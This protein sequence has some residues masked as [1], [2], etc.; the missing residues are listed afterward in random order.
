MDGFIN[1]VTMNGKSD[2]SR[3]KKII[4]AGGHPGEEA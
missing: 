2:V 1:I 4:A 3:A